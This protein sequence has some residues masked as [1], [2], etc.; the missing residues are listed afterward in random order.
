MKKTIRFSFQEPSRK[1]TAQYILVCK[2]HSVSPNNILLIFD[3]KK[4]LKKIS[5]IST[6]W[7]CAVRGGEELMDS[8][9]EIY[10][11]SDE[12]D[13]KHDAFSHYLKSIFKD[14]NSI[15]LLSGT[16]PRISIATELLKSTIQ[17][18]SLRRFI[19]CEY[20]DLN[21]LKFSQNRFDTLTNLDYTFYHVTDI[22][23]DKTSSEIQTRETIEFHATQ[24]QIAKKHEKDLKQ[25]CMVAEDFFD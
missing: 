17:I 22:S 16:S 20:A 12:I 21:Q 7:I 6:W 10:C 18:V 11:T 5:F 19:R 15:D 13:S 4:K 25:L 24:F 1:S 23:I 9:Y 3:D 14:S 2:C 8:F